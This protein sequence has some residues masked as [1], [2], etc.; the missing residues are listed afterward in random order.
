MAGLIT[1]AANLGGGFAPSYAGLFMSKLFQGLANAAFNVVAAV[2]VADLF[3]L[4]ERGA[5]TGVWTYLTN[6]G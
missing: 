5:K 2:T 4:H 6:S 1:F 3:F